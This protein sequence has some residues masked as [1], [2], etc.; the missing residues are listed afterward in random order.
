MKYKPPANVNLLVAGLVATLDFDKIVKT[1]NCLEWSWDG[2]I[3]APTLSKLK[4]IATRLLT[5]ML[6]KGHSRQAT[7][8]FEA[9]RNGEEFGIRFVVTSTEIADFD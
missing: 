8:G 1:M 5:D 3:D 4:E 7:G 6:E 9:W 2:S